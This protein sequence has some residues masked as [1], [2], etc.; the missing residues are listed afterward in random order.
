MAP[1]ERDGDGVHD[2]AAVRALD[3]A[4]ATLVAALDG[5]RSVALDA[6]RPFTERAAALARAGRSLPAVP[7]GPAATAD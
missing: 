5:A 1:S 4:I 2:D 3:A 7:R 6:S